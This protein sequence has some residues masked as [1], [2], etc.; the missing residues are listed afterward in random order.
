MAL[1]IKNEQFRNHQDVF[2]LM[3]KSFCCYF[4]FQLNVN[5]LMWAWK[6]WKEEK[7][8]SMSPPNVVLRNHHTAELKVKHELRKVGCNCEWDSKFNWNCCRY[9]FSVAPPICK[10]DGS[11]V[12]LL[13]TRCVARSSVWVGFY[14]CCCKNANSFLI[15]I[16]VA[17]KTVFHF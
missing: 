7:K 9:F 11:S 4:T 12:C 6:L 2:F 15:T 5:I 17:G 16:P 13:T 14:A 10:Q 3:C 8:D 1:T